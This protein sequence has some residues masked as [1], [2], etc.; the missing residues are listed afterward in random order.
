MH[1]KTNPLTP[2]HTHT[3]CALTP[4]SQAK[5]LTTDSQQS[6]P[7]PQLHNWPSVC[8]WPSVW[9][10]SPCLNIFTVSAAHWSVSTYFLC[11]LFLLPCLPIPSTPACLNGDD[12][13]DQFC[14]KNSL[15][16][17]PLLSDEKFTAVLCSFTQ[18]CSCSDCN[19]I[20][21]IHISHAGTK[22]SLY[23]KNRGSWKW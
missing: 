4:T 20:S 12:S 16:T 5:F 7:P 10:Q 6:K 15:F 8:V 3:H 18:S 14:Y 2:T 17:P 13:I 21:V 9:L 23:P 1:T 19:M 11:P 22:Q